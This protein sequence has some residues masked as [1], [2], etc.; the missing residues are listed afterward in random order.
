MSTTKNYLVVGGSHGIGLGITQNLSSE[1]HSVTVLSRTRGEIEGLAGVDHLPFD[2]TQD[3]LAKDQLPNELH[4]MVYCPGS[5]NLQSF[6]GLKPDRFRDDFELNVIGAVKTIQ[7][8]LPA[9]KRSGEASLVLFS[10]VAVGKGLFAHSSVAASKGALEGLARTLAS[11]LAPNV[12][13]N[14]I[15][16]ALTDTPLASK[17]FEKEE[18]AA[19]MAEKYPLKRTGTIEDMAEMSCFLLSS[20]SGWITGQTI[21]VDGGMSTLG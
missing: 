12:R 19:A 13:V 7:A 4:G 21:H 3:E 20:K 6:R 8:A 1:G 9:L 5:I 17:F 2:V 16:P 10:T 15:A 18:K 11:E 14:C